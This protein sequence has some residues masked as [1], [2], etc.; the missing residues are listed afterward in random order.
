MALLL[1]GHDY[2]RD[3]KEKNNYLNLKREDKS[4]KEKK[5]C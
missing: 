5:K 4:D 3:E 1:T 2:E